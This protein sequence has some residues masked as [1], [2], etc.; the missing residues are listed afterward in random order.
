VFIVILEYRIRFF[1]FRSDVHFRLHDRKKATIWVISIDEC[2]LVTVILNI[3]LLPPLKFVIVKVAFL[4]FLL[5]LLCLFLFSE[6]KFKVLV[7][8]RILW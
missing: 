2:I 8:V 4:F 6:V 7:E 3:D 1:L 5:F